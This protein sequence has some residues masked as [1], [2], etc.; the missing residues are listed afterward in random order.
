MNVSFFQTVWK[1]P[2]IYYDFTEL[3]ITVSTMVFSQA[4]VTLMICGVQAEWTVISVHSI[5]SKTE[6][7]SR[8]QSFSGLLYNFL[9]PGSVPAGDGPFQTPLG[10]LGCGAGHLLHHELSGETRSAKDD[11]VVG[12][13]GWSAE[14]RHSA[15][16]LLLI[17][18]ETDCEQREEHLT[19]EAT[20]VARGLT[21][22]TW[23][24][25]R[26]INV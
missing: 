6:V 21:R 25:H 8:T 9:Q 15:V 13:A 14:R 1:R 18:E 19:V 20:S 5:Q 12:S 3:S 16:E 2:F 4:M 26:I 24:H 7:A 17:L 10:T 22:S 23:S 11:D